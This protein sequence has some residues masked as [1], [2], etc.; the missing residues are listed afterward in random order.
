M[1]H[2]P[3]VVL[4]LTLGACSE[5]GITTAGGNGTGTGSSGSSGGKGTAPGSVR[6]FPDAGASAGGG[7]GG[8]VLNPDEKNCGLMTFKLEQRPAELLLILDRS[9]SMNDPAGPMSMASKWT[10]VTGALDETIMKTQSLV[11]WGLK[12]FPSTDM[13]CNVADGVEVPSAMMNYTPVWGRIQA[14]APGTGAGGGTPTTLAVQKAVTYL[15]ATPSMNP[16]YIVLATDGEPNCGAG[17]GGG[18]GGGGF[19]SNDDAAAI[20]AVADALAAGYKTFVIGVA[21]MGSLWR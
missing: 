4:A 2:L 8:G 6:D 1:K 15:N 17:G 3:C 20:K 13:R 14:S 21:L 5:P 19:G 7:K 9:G 11:L 16:R 10:D 12:T 18:F